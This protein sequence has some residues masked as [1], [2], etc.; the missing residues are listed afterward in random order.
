MSVNVE[1]VA[2]LKSRMENN[3]R[4]CILPFWTNHMEDEENGGFYGAVRFDMTPVKTAR[5]AIVLN[6]R[7]LWAFSRAYREYG[8][9]VFKKLAKR[10][11]EYIKD[12][13]W[14]KK[15]G[16]VYWML[17]YKGEPL[18]IEKRTY[19]QAFI[20]Y[21]LAEYY[22][23]FGDEEAKA[24]AMETFKKINTAAKYENGGYA[25]SMTRDWQFDKNIWRW[26]MNPHGAAKLLNSHLHLF[27]ATLALYGATHDD[28]VLGVLKEFLEFLLDNAIDYNVMH[29]KA[30]MDT[31]TNRI[32]SE[33]DYGHDSECC[34][35]LCQAADI[36][37]DPVLSSKTRDVVISIMSKVLEEGIDPTSGAIN[38]NTD[39]STGLT[40]RAKVWWTQCEG[41]TAFFNCYQLTEEEKY[42]DAA[43]G[44]WNYIED[45]LV[46]NENGEW[47]PVGMDEDVP[48]ECINAMMAFF[49]G[50]ADSGKGPYHNSRTCFEIIERAER[51]LK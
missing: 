11:F 50:K 6:T 24:M 4:E 23:A 16:G 39:F 18:E 40:N 20:I 21:S 44:I 19:G 43:I 15:Y 9:D 10:G 31:E 48:G 41:V 38:A 45:K 34:Y 46:D 28:Y 1:K 14:D 25:D 33:I 36:I 32:D 13:F 5:K 42:L 29:L 37:E 26:N 35:L 8:D 49:T 17:N 2:A 12:N 3:L 30:G 51:L 47:H 27:E 7:M 22:R